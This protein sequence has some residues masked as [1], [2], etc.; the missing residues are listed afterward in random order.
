M[1]EE[2]SCD[3]KGM[4]R[5]EVMCSGTSKRLI[6]LNRRADAHADEAASNIGTTLN[7]CV[8]D[9]SMV[10]KRYWVPSEGGKG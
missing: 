2:E 8:V 10:V 6:Y 5:L 4:P 1:R 9:L 3:R 7:R